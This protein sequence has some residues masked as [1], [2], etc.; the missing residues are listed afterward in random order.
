MDVLSK[1]KKIVK[2]NQ[3]KIVIFY[4]YEKSLYVAWACFRNG[5]LGF[6]D[7]SSTWSLDIFYF[8]YNQNPLAFAVNTFD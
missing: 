7:C 3:M 4:W 6:S 8:Y 1:N 5:Y 2:K